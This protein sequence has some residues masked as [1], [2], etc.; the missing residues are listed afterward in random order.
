MFEVGDIAN[1]AYVQLLQRRLTELEKYSDEWVRVFKEIQ[2]LQDAS[3]EGQLKVIEAYE[4]GRQFQL[5]FDQLA[6]QRALY[7]QLTPAS[8]GG[9]TTTII[10]STS[11]SPSFTANGSDAQQAMDTSSQKLRD[12]AVSR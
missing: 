9:A 12:F 2:Q 5:G 10:H 3:L 11:W 6:Q 1:D 7:G 8:S 4:A